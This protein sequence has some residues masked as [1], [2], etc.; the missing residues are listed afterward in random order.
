MPFL[1]SFEYPVSRTYPGRVFAPFA[2]GG[3]LVVLL[4]LATINTALA[5]YETVTGFDSDFN[6]TQTLWLNRFLPSAAKSM[7]G[8]LCDPRLL[9]LGDTITTNYS[10][11][12]YTIASVNTANAG[13]S[14]FLYHGWILDNCDIT[15]LYVN[16]DTNTF[17]ID[18][19]VLVTCRPDEAQVRQGINFE[20][21]A[22]ADFTESTL[23]G[24]YG[25]L[26][27]DQK[28]GI[29][30]QSLDARTWVRSSILATSGAE[31][32]TRSLILQALT[33]GSFPTIISFRAQFPWCPASFGPDAAC[34]VQVPHL[35]V[36]D[37][38]EYTPSLGIQLYSSS[39]QFTEPL[40]TNDTFGII[41]N[42]VQAVYAAVRLDLGNP[43]PNNFLLN[44]SM[45]S[46]AVTATFPQTHPNRLGI[47]DLPT[48]SYLYSI[49]V[50][51]GHYSTVTVDFSIA[52]LLPLTSPG[53]GVL[54]GVYLCRFQRA[55]PPRSAFIAVLVATLSMFTTGWS[56]FLTIAEA[57][58]K[59]HKPDANVCQGH[60]DATPYESEPL[61]EGNVGAMPMHP[62]SGT[63]L[64]QRRDRNVESQ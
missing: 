42:T 38:F 12:Q 24:K 33:N 57:V 43:S 63:V 48:H 37:M 54:D 3:G 7:P 10:M 18:Y 17:M 5:G 19:T 52:G 16:G 27:R 60:T 41:S 20:I 53:P 26:F 29:S 44:I 32:A 9:G 4:L 11:F 35:N 1:P 6:M 23:S 36:T 58:V 40:I 47:L 2:L 8:T 62:R 61:L 49:L 25:T 45:I 30:N 14:G 21:T 64:S 51:D 31:F 46:D 15:S 13:D 28:A 34:A 39:G 22:R 55:K 59:R 50:D 56:I